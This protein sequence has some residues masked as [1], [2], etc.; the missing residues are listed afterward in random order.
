M[1]RD[2]SGEAVG[3]PAI[4][5]AGARDPEAYHLFLR[6]H[7]LLTRGGPESVAD[8][9]SVLE[10]ALD[11]IGQF[12]DKGAR[13]SSIISWKSRRKCA[14]HPTS[15]MIEAKPASIAGVAD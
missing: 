3:D 7:W 4:D 5:V 15:A 9:I 6:G 12:A 2:V 10:A 11:R 8:A 1:R 13:C 14:W